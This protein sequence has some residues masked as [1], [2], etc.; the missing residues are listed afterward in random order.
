MLKFYNRK[1]YQLIADLY[2]L[3]KINKL[4]Y[5]HKGYQSPKVAIKT[6]L[7]K[8]V[9]SKNKLSDE[10]DIISKSIESLQFEVDVLNAIKGLQTP[11]FVKS[12]KGRYIEKFKD[13]FVTIY[14]FID[15]DTPK[16]NTPKMAHAL[17]LFLAKFHNQSKNF[18]KCPASR[19][20][21]YDLN[22]RVM[23]KMRP[24]A[25]K[26]NNNLLKSVVGEI[27][28]GVKRNYSPSSLPNGVIHVDIYSGNELFKKEK[29]T[30]IID[31][32]NAY[33]GP[34]MIDVGKT[35]MWNCCING[36]LDKNLLR[37]FIKGYEN[38][39]KL[40]KPEREYLKKS[41]LYA[42]YSHI[43]VDLYHV[44]IQYVPVKYALFLVKSF[45]PVARKL[46]IEQS[47]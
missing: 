24:L 46:E 8:F 26:Q 45:L 27:E 25:Y 5:L 40:T 44:P 6:S 36:R 14:K 31:F 47:S 39:R 42:I 35:I 10:K 3:G 43:W 34:L 9:I 19:R 18:K 37:E 20:K 32:G 4:F 12:K 23:K 29:L 13:D 7:G 15:G 38:I 1:D 2:G 28:S 21:F 17:G 11:S 41:I 30:G 33:V 22:P 16:K